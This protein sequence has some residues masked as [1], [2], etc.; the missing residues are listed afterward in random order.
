MN[1]KTLLVTGGAGFIGSNFIIYM[2]DKYP[3]HKII[4]F[5]VLT[6]AGNLDNL[7]SVENNRNYKFV[8]GDIS[9]GQYVAA[10]MKEVD[11]VIHFAA[12]SHVDRSIEGPEI[13]VKTNVLGTQ[14]LLDH[15]K[16]NKIKKFVHVSTDE[17]YG[18]L[19]KTGYFTESTP[20]SPN[21]PYSASKAGSDLIVRSY[22]ETFGFPAVITRCSNNYGPFQFPEKLIPLMITNALENKPLPV[23]GDGM[24]VRDWLYVEDHCSAIDRVLHD[25]KLGEVY[26]IGGNN[27]WHNI[28]IVK[29]I[30]KE[31]NKP[32]TLIKYV[33]DRLG[34]DRRYAIDAAKIKNELGWEP[35]VQFEEGIKKTIQ[36]YLDNDEWII[37]VKCHS[38]A[39]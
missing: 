10:I 11:Y 9:N 22:Y 36:W 24:N 13:F 17:V 33:E 31:L 8:K 28:D 5:D 19:G 1:R 12:E 23:Y 32:E 37:N 35:S 29:L 7:R 15:A 21:S 38:E 27:E 25:G 14:V 39:R 30:L 16:A 6:Y 34:H 20:I 4:N 18:S 3:N 26:N 2:L